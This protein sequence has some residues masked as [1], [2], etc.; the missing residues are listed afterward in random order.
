[1][2]HTKV[3][4]PVAADT[5]FADMRAAYDALEGLSA[6]HSVA[7]SRW[8]LGFDFSDDEKAQLAGAVHPSRRHRFCPYCLRRSASRRELI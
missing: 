6:H 5:E 2:L 8:R 3:I 1:M 4:P 7:H